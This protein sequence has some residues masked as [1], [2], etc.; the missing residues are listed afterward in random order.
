MERIAVS[1]TTTEYINEPIVEV[2]FGVELGFLGYSGY[3]STKAE[4]VSNLLEALKEDDIGL[5]EDTIEALG[6]IARQKE[7]NDGA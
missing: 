1:K 7:Q 5:N 2:S 4:A 6:D 3:G